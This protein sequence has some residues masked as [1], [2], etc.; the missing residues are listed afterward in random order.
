MSLPGVSYCFVTTMSK[1][2]ETDTQTNGIINAYICVSLWTAEA[3]H[4]ASVCVRRGTF[5]LSVDKV[6]PL[7][8]HRI[9]WPVIQWPCYK[10]DNVPTTN[11][12]AYSPNH[13]CRK[14]AVGITYSEC[15]YSSL[16]IRY[17]KRINHI[18]LSFVNV[19]LN[20]IFPH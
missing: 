3:V 7:R 18:I 2:R 13:C 5:V 8:H 19:W 1:Y 15:V 12:G 17:A 16:L 10:K 14:I 4:V 20:N 11:I 6:S 9:Q